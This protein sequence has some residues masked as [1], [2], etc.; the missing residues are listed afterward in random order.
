MDVLEKIVALRKRRNWTVWKLA[1][2]SGVDQSTISAWYNKGRSPSI[3]SLEKICE[4][5]GITMSQFFAEGSMVVELTSEQKELLENWS[6]LGPKQKEA[7]LALIQSIPADIS[8]VSS[9]QW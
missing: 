7:I 3:V 5:F 8:E 1:E 9:S 6:A 2:E 4:A